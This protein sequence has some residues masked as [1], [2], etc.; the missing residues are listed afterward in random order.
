[1]EEHS[2]TPTASCILRVRKGSGLLGHELL[3]HDSHISSLGELS[4]RR[5]RGIVRREYVCG[6]CSAFGLP[7]P[8][9]APLRHAVI[10]IRALCTHCTSVGYWDPRRFC[11]GS[12]ISPRGFGGPILHKSSFGVSE[13]TGPSIL[14]LAWPFGDT[15][16]VG[17]VMQMIEHL[18]IHLTIG[19]CIRH[20]EFQIKGLQSRLLKRAVAAQEC[21]DSTG[22][23][24][25]SGSIRQI[26]I[27][28]T[29]A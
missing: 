23:V 11:W 22:T 15:I 13:T 12:S 9:G 8:V 26:Q 28:L 4:I 16:L 29:L 19:Y 21:Q 1:M 24:L 7:C 20:H 25:Y 6:L 3:R 17:T 2:Q 10:Y 5:S 18:A 14:A 27:R